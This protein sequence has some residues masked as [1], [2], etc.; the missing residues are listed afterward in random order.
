[1][2]RWRSASGQTWRAKG[3]G[4]GDGS[5]RR[6]RRREV[7]PGLGADCGKKQPAD[8]EFH[9]VHTS[10]PRVDTF[11]EE[12]DRASRGGLWLRS[13]RLA[14]SAICCLS[15]K[16]VFRCCARKPMGRRGWRH[17]GEGWKRIGL[18]RSGSGK[19]GAK[20]RRP[21]GSTRAPTVGRPWPE[22]ERPVWSAQS[23]VEVGYGNDG[24]GAAFR[25][26]THET[27]R[28]HASDTW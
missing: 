18:V 6:T 14:R 10:A 22:P 3:A 28:C 26:F 16:L 11:T 19:T 9:R 7:G 24:A 12:F 2:T 25:H 23:H 13:R 17:P 15:A 21:S 4:I 8:T 1:M 27:G 5:R 20:R